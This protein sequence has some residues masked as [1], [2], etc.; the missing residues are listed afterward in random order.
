MLADH[1]SDISVT[2]VSESN[3]GEHTSLKDIWSVRAH[4]PIALSP[5]LNQNPGWSLFATFLQRLTSPASTPFC[6]HIMSRQAYV[7]GNPANTGVNKIC[8]SQDG[9][10]HLMYRYKS[11]YAGMQGL[12][13]PTCSGCGLHDQVDWYEC[14]HCTKKRCYQCRARPKESMASTQFI[15]GAAPV[16][17]PAPEY[18][19]SCESTQI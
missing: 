19:W 9:H 1:T 16:V 10:K 8:S 2:G 4:F 18:R 3:Q 11:P 6:L 15:D 17:L 12:K 5:G 14:I 13:L 7:Q